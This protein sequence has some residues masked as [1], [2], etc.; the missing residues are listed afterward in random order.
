MLV[1][2]LLDSVLF[3]QKVF[4]CLLVLFTFCS[5]SPGGS[6][7][8]SLLSSFPSLTE[9]LWIIPEDAKVKGEP[10]FQATSLCKSCSSC[11]F[12]HTPTFWMLWL[13][14]LSL[15]FKVW[16][17]L[18]EFWQLCLAEAC[19]QMM[20]LKKGKYLELFLP[21]VDSSLDSV[22]LWLFSNIFW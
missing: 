10:E 22:Y 2:E 17:F 3:V 21:G 11:L 1:V 8:K 15:S 9:L 6:K 14:T 19:F 18:L 16:G 5:A 4:I 20:I 12:G 13:W 7:L